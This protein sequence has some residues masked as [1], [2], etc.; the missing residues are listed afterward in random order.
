MKAKLKAVPAIHKPTF[1][2]PRYQRVTMLVVGAR[3]TTVQR[4]VANVLCM[5]GKRRPAKGRHARRYKVLVSGQREARSAAL[6][7]RPRRDRL[8]PAG[9]YVVATV[10]FLALP[11]SIRRQ[12]SSE[13][14]QRLPHTACPELKR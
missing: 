8:V 2:H 4:T 7:V 6:G 11:E 14:T 1:H 5:L 10:Q 12:I 13:L 3:V 9:L